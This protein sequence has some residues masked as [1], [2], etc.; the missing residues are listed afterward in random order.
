MNTEKCVHDGQH[1]LNCCHCDKDGF[2]RT[3]SG[4]DVMWKCPGDGDCDGYV[5]GAEDG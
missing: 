3:Y 5:E 4:Y 2:C 1:Q